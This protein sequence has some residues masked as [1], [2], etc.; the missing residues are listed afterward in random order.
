MELAANLTLNKAIGTL[1]KVAT[2]LVK[3]AEKKA[4]KIATNKQKIDHLEVDNELAFSDKEKAERI[5]KRINEL[6]E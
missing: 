4:A 5:A 3:V 6:L 2:D 1:Q